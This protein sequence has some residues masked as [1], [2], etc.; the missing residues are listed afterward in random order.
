M[1]SW[2]FLTEFPVVFAIYHS[3]YNVSS[4]GL[5]FDKIQEDLFDFVA[6]ATRTETKVYKQ[7]LEVLLV[8]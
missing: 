2:E 8:E 7:R 4:V 6:M 3:H 1:L 5:M